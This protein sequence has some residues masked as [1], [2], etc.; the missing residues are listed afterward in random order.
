VSTSSSV[1]SLLL[2]IERYGLGLNYL[3]DY[4]KA[5]EVVTPADVQEVAKKHIDP[6]RMMLVAA[7]AVDAQGKPVQKLPPPKQ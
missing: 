1:A 4:R 2:A 3:D 6:K 5:V 7:G